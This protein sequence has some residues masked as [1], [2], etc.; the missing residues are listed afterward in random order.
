MVRKIADKLVQKVEI[1]LDG[2][3]SPI[4]ISTTS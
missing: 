2:K 1:L 3:T 4:V